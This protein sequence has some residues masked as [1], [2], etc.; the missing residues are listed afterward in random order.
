MEVIELVEV[1]A[2]VVVASEMDP[3]A[4]S[5]VRLSRPVRQLPRNVAFM[6]GAAAAATDDRHI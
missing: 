5:E 6:V 1:K 3:E 2:V 4:V